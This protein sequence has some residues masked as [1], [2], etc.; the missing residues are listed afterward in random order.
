MKYYRTIKLQGGTYSS[1]RIINFIRHSL[2]FRD[3]KRVC[4]SVS[5]AGP[6]AGKCDGAKGII[7]F[8]HHEE[9]KLFMNR[10]MQRKDLFHKNTVFLPSDYVA[11]KPKIFHP[12]YEGVRQQTKTENE[13]YM[14]FKTNIFNPEYDGVRR[15]RKTEKDLPRI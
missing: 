3:E 10:I 5:R 12:Q 2:K 4:V 13:I 7:K 1:K 15:Q 9:A 11:T 14:D 8:F 6:V